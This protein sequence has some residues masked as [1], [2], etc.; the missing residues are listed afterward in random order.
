MN[1]YMIKHSLAVARKMFVI[2]PKNDTTRNEWSY[3]FRVHILCNARYVVP[4][5][6]KVS[7]PNNSE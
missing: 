4:I 5:K 2:N 3:G 1:E 7:L 6:Y